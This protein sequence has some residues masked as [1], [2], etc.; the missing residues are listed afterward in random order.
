MGDQPLVQMAG[1]QGD[2][3]GRRMVAKEMAGEAHLVA[4]AGSQQRPLQPRPFLHRL[5]A[6][7]RDAGQG[8]RDH[9]L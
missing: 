5:L 1:Q 3:L 2:A 8:D 7:G 4:A 9:D 6:G